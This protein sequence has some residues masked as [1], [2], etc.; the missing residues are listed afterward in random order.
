MRNSFG[1]IEII[2]IFANIKEHLEKL[3]DKVLPPLG[4]EVAL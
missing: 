3:Y 2:C 1:G 4:E